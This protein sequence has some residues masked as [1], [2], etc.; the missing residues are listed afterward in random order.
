MAAALRRP[1]PRRRHFP[2]HRR[3]LKRWVLACLRR[4]VQRAAEL[5]DLTLSRACLRTV[6]PVPSPP[7]FPLPLPLCRTQLT[8]ILNAM[9]I[10]PI[11]LPSVLHEAFISYCMS[12]LRPGLHNVLET[13]AQRIFPN[14]TSLE[15]LRKGWEHFT[16]ANEAIA[17]VVF[18]QYRDGDVVWINDYHLSMM[19]RCLV[20]W[21][22]TAFGRRP[23]QVRAWWSWA[24]SRGSP[25]PRAPPLPFLQL[26]FLHAPFPTSEI[27]RTLP[28]RDELLGECWGERAARSLSCAAHAR[29]PLLLC[30]HVQAPYLNATLSASTRSTTPATSCT[31]P[32]G[33]LVRGE[34]ELKR[35]RCI[36]R[37]GDGSLPSTRHP[38]PTP[39]GV[40]F[41]SRRGG[42]LALD[43][44]GRNTM[45]AISHVGVEAAALN[46]WMASEQAADVARSFALR[47]PGKTIIAGIDS[48]QRLSGVALK[49]LAFERLLQVCVAEAVGRGVA[50]T[51]SG[52]CLPQPTFPHPI[53]SLYSACCG[54]GQQGVPLQSR[55]RPALRDA[56]GAEC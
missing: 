24:A 54:T 16:E 31:L 20:K 42:Q 49:L 1:R 32:S 39:A 53:S 38:T 11:F 50:C 8:G 36:H 27:F 55:P 23:P 2:L 48:C 52:V 4:P 3:T 5:H 44:H 26:F 17:R 35:V 25:A 41:Q 21:C 10:V 6:S 30:M 28:V 18:A 46:R 14:A 7:L 22:F 47:H 15:Y 51:A 45:V 29:V 19:P 9:N 40:P 37:T 56:R 12:V 34:G 13:G 33:S 43:V